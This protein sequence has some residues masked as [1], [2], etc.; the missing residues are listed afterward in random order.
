[1]EIAWLGHACFRLRGRDATVITDPCPPTTGYRIGRVTADVVTVSQEQS[2]FNY[3]QA[4]TGE[5]KFVSGPGEYEIAGVLITGVNT[6]R[7]GGSNRN[8]A[9]VV[10]V[11]DVRICHLG[12][13]S[14]APPA[15][16]VEALS[17]ADVLLVPVGGG[18]VFDYARAAETIS[19][20]EPKLVVPMVYKTDAATGE[21]DSVERFLK[22][23]GAEGKAAEARLNVTKSNVPSDTTVVVLNYRG[24]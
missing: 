22:E 6:D 14:Q 12:G 16:D 21:L 3:R 20:L 5:A 11:D 7:P 13:I 15:D 8:V 23:M 18:R 19:R 17:A 4:V 2:E 24:S 1:M 10:D 9:Y